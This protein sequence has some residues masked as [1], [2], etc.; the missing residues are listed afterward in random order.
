MD[1]IEIKRFNI[2]RTGQLFIEIF[3]YHAQMDQRQKSKLQD[4]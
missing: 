1:I 3:Y 2:N 4:F